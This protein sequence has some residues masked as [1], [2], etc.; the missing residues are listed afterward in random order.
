MEHKKLNIILIVMLL[1]SS[2]AFA[3]INYSVDGQNYTE[4]LLPL[5]LS[6][7]TPARYVVMSDGVINVNS[8]QQGATIINGTTYTK[9]NQAVPDA[10]D[11]R[12]FIFYNPINARGTCF[13]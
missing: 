8:N 13:D 1:L 11:D 2:S 10:T 3:V 4:A 6:G 7:A 12:Y 9:V 5:N